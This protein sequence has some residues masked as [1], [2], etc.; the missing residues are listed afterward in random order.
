MRRRCQ[1]CLVLSGFVGAL[2]LATASPPNGLAGLIV[3]S[4]KVI[5]GKAM[6]IAVSS[7]NRK[8]ITEHAGKCREFWIYKIDKG[9]ISDK[10][11]LELPMEQTLHASHHQLPGPLAAINVLISGSIGAGLHHRLMQAGIQPII[12]VEESPDMAVA[13]YLEGRLDWL[14]IDHPHHCHGH[15][16]G[17]GHTLSCGTNRR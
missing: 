1:L 15:G 14:P 12:T 3:A 7:Q 9:E 13:A 17:Y 6:Q 8:T 10:R 11:L 4:R 2:P 16:H 5:K